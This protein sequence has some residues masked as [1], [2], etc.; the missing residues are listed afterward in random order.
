MVLP[1]GEGGIAMH[2]RLL[3]E[4]AGSACWIT[5]PRSAARRN[6][7]AYLKLLRAVEMDTVWGGF[8]FEG[9]LLRPG[10]TVP[11]DDLCPGPGWP[12][13][14]LLLECAGPGG[15]GWGHRRRPTLY[16]LWRY[17]PAAGEFREVARMA[18]QNRDWTLD[19]G[20][21][22]RR[23]L[24]PPGPVLIDPE[25]L[26]RRLIAA[27]DREMEPLD[28]EAQRIVLLAFYDRVASRVVQ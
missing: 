25:G 9:L 23:L 26:S 12:E 27:L 19:L 6:S 16:I 7:I 11:V 10:E 20:P 17:D 18:S 15:T 4:I 8:C 21:I 5:L 22:A 13:V 14:P 28:R 2:G 3:S 24:R 1:T